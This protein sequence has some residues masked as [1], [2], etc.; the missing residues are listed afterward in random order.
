MESIARKIL[1]IVRPIHE[2]ADW[3]GVLEKINTYNSGIVITT[4]CADEMMHTSK[5]LLMTVEQALEMEA[6]KPFIIY[7]FHT[8]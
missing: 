3:E 1:L 4:A 6:K 8:Q 7:A 5:Y 2:S